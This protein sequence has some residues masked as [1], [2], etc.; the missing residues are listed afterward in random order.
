[1][2]IQ[3]GSCSKNQ[4]RHSATSEEFQPQNCYSAA[5]EESRI[6][7]FQVKKSKKRSFGLRPQDDTER[8]IYK[9]FG[10]PFL[11]LAF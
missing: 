2:S 11:I 8:Q 9:N 1:M 4:Y 10:T 5:G 7:S 3:N 6:F